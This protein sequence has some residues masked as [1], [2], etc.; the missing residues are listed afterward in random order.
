MEGNISLPLEDYPLGGPD[1]IRT[2]PWSAWPYL[3]IAGTASVVGTAGNLLILGSVYCYKRLRKARNAFI[4][5]LAI[6]DLC[7]TSFADPLGILGKHS[8]KWFQKSVDFDS[9]S[10]YIY[11][12]SVLSIVYMTASRDHRVFLYCKLLF[13]TP[14]VQFEIKS[15]PLL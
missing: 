6:A 7:V 4:V 2:R 11:S 15:L 8:K 3:L 12:L 13:F 5:N 1:Y 10:T 14:N 9:K